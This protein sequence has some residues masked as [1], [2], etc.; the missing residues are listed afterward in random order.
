MPSSHPIST[1]SAAPSTPLLVP[2]LLTAVLLLAGSAQAVDT[3]SLDH[4]DIGVAYDSADPTAFEMEV[5]IEPGGVVNGVR[6]RILPA[7]PSSLPTS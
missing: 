6:S 5:H 4:G 7:R 1:H 2:R 3:W